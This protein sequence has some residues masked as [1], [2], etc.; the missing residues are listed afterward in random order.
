MN[1]TGFQG[2]LR[3]VTDEK[4]PQA[5]KRYLI[6]SNCLIVMS[7]SLNGVRRREALLSAKYGRH[8]KFNVYSGTYHDPD[9]SR[10]G[11]HC[12]P[13][14]TSTLLPLY[15]NRL[16]GDQSKLLFANV[17]R[18]LERSRDGKGGW[19][20]YPFYYT[21]LGVLS[22]RDKNLTRA[23]LEYALTRKTLFKDSENPVVTYVQDRMRRL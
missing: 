16:M 1:V 22:S 12:C 9:R 7:R 8:T 18:I 10:F 4:V 23:E 13:P 6:E 2:D 20:R 3:T 21:L 15:G 17:L 11:Y 19:K 14:C 5:T